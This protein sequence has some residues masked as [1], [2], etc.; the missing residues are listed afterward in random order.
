MAYGVVHFF[1]GGTKEQYDASVAAVHP[2]GGLPPGQVLHVAGP[3]EGGWTI[4]AVHETQESW[5]AFRDKTL[6]PR[7]QEGIRGGFEMP[8]EERAFPVDTM[9]P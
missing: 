6:I 8:P 7:L 3:T 9:L 2:G 4:T 5:E 1:P